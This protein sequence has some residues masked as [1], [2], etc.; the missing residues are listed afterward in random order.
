MKNV[1]LSE[2][3]EGQLVK[4]KNNSD[5]YRVQSNG[6]FITLLNMYTEKEMTVKCYTMKGGKMH[7]RK[8]ETVDFY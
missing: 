7:D 1:K 2:V 5:V 8:V 4:F 6:Y 3:T